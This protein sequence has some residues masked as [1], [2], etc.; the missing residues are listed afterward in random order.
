M[1]PWQVPWP[2]DPEGRLGDEGNSCHSGGSPRKWM[3]WGCSG[4]LNK[5]CTND[6]FLLLPTRASRLLPLP[7]LGQR[8]SCSPFLCLQES[9]TGSSPKDRGNVHSDSKMHLS[10]GPIKSHQGHQNLLW[11]YSVLAPSQVPPGLE[12]PAWGTAIPILQVREW[13]GWWLHK[14]KPRAHTGLLPCPRHTCPGHQR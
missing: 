8:L 6:L 13:Q 12:T 2:Q 4:C 11:P 3:A 1:S 5:R 7:P 14:A 9:K 10:A